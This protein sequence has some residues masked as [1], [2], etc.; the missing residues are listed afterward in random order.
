MYDLHEM[1]VPTR[2]EIM[3]FVVG[4]FAPD[5]FGGWH[6]IT[7]IYA[8]KEDI[9]GKLFICYYTKHGENGQISN[10]LKEGELN[11]T[12]ALSGKHTSHELDVIEREIRT[13]RG[14]N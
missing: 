1:Y 3:N 14:I 2:Q 10:S 7:R 13:L 12:V 5:C 11:R 4:S 6:E 8:Y 9:H